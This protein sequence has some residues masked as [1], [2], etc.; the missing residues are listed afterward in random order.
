VI[1]PE[2]QDK[3]LPRTLE[4][5]LQPFGGKVDKDVP[6]METGRPFLNPQGTVA[7]DNRNVTEVARYLHGDDPD[8]TKLASVYPRGPGFNP[9]H[10]AKGLVETLTQ[11]RPELFKPNM[12]KSPGLARLTPEILQQ[13]RDKGFPLAAIM[14]MMQTQQDK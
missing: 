13:L 8:P 5:L 12:V 3:Q 9:D 7:E 14:A 1:S 11:N 6:F 10:E 2:F 4:K